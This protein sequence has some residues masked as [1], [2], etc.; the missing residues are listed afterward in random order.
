MSQAVD[1]AYEARAAFEQMTISRA[2]LRK[3]VRLSYIEE[4]PDELVDEY[5]DLLALAFPF[6][7]CDL[8]TG[9]L[10]EQYGQGELIIGTYDRVPHVCLGLFVGL[11]KIIVDITADQFGGPPV[12]VG[13]LVAPWTRTPH[14]ELFAR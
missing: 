9:Y 7:N 13:P 5:I 12:Y 8:A 6:E 2:L 3:V 4:I 14:K 1:I 11:E 10:L